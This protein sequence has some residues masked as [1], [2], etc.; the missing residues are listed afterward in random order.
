MNKG[1]G[2]ERRGAGLTNGRKLGERTQ[3]HVLLLLLQSTRLPTTFDLPSLGGGYN[4]LEVFG[5][6][7]VNF[8]L[9]G[10]G[11]EEVHETLREVFA[12]EDLAALYPQL[13]RQTLTG[14]PRLQQLTKLQN[15]GGEKIIN[16][17]EQGYKV[18]VQNPNVQNQ[19]Q[20]CIVSP[21]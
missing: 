17:W 9:R 2:R 13:S 5:L 8:L 15:V 18:L 19:C 21:L 6:H 16:Y 1:K 11:P 3:K 7:G 20:L 10:N 12:N 14:E 4:T